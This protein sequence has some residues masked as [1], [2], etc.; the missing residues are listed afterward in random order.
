MLFARAFWRCLRVAEHLGTGAAVALF[1]RLR[2]RRGVAP[3]WLPA[4]V[5]WWHRRLYRALG[6]DLRVAGR[7]EPD[8]L[9]VG[10][11]ISWL[12]I[13]L[14]GAQGEIGF[15]AK[16]DVRGWPLIGWMAEIAGTLFIERGGNQ[17]SA[18]ARRIAEDVARGR[19][20]MIFPE[21]TTTDGTCVR[22]F[23]PRLFG[24]AQGSGP[25]IQ[26]VAISYHRGEDPAADDQAPYVGDD[27]LIANLW[28][29]MLHPD[30]VARVRFLPPIHADDGAQRR[31]LAELTRDAIL[32]ALELDPIAA[33]TG[34]NIAETPTANGVDG[35]DL[36][37]NPA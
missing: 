22:R 32:S 15:L 30:L 33:K 20:L 19:S 18:V 9:L 3:A 23:H 36:G 12:D 35:L 11:H 29:L 2:Y 37:A 31:A 7:F 5:R 28:R 21:G 17:T 4:V 14:V 13:P 26:P 16:A 27:S 1:I 24:I 6:V 34:S 8:C 25:R 10:N